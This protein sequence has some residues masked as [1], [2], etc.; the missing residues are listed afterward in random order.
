MALEILG[1]EA[2]QPGLKSIPHLP[3]SSYVSLSKFLNFSK[4]QFLHLLKG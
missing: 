4:L 2:V 3:L 1:S